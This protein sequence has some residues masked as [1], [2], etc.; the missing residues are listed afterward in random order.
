M[1]LK[2]KLP[3]GKYSELRPE[4]ILATL[5]KLQNRINER[6]P[7]SGLGQVALELNQVAAAIV[8][9]VQKMRRPL[10]SIRVLTFLTIGLLVGL[11]VWLCVLTV[12]YIPAG[13]SGLVD[14]LQGSESAINEVIFLS[15]AIFF[16]A[17]LETRLK[18]QTALRS[19]HQL[20]SIAHVVDMHQLT[21]D[22]AY[23]LH[24][25]APTAASPERTM[26][27]SELARY[28]DYCIELL[29]LT[30][31]LAA[32]HVQYFQDSE[33]LKTVNEVEM[34]AHELSGKIWQK[35]MALNVTANGA[36]QERA[37]GK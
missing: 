7:G 22:P 23:L 16:L 19:L 32:L 18:R 1:L 3:Y 33:V 29:A 27:A 30:S 8:E 15:L 35:L 12:R 36:G 4:L 25:S 2:G 34:L 26:T 28:F 24:G 20:R 11:A 37:K 9:L 31:K 17:T 13:E 5:D 21:K 6:F 14:L 10:W